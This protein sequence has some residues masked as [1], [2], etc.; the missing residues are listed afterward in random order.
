[1]P[2][3]KQLETLALQFILLGGWKK[4]QKQAPKLPTRKIL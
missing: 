2:T 1:M 3:K 4:K